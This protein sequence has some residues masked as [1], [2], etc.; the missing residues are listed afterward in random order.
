[1]SS[2]PNVPS[3]NPPVP[4]EAPKPARSFLSIF[5]QVLGF[6]PLVGPVVVAVEQIHGNAVAGADKKTL[7]L[8]SLGLAVNVGKTVVPGVGTQID[9]AGQFA[10]GLINLWVDFYNA[11][12]WAHPAA[13]AMIPVVTAQPVPPAQPST[14]NVANP[15][16]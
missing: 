8:Q 10:S 13:G 4:V 11:T 7:A 14:P 6:L 9:A 12:G 15:A 5:S 16:P 3:P 1:M 2:N